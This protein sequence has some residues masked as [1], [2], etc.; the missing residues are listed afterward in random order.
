MTKQAQPY[1]VNIIM[2]LVFICTGALNTSIYAQQDSLDNPIILQD[3]TQQ[4]ANNKKAK[5]QKNNKFRP[6]PR[7]A[8]LLA[9]LPGGGQIY[10][11]SY[12]KIPI[13]YGGFVGLGY[14]VL[15]SRQKYQ[16]YRKAYLAAVD[17]TYSVLPICGID[18]SITEVSQLKSLRDNNQ[19]M[20]EWSVI[21]FTAFYGLTILEAFVNAHL[22]SFDV[23]DDLTMTVR[24]GLRYNSL[25]RNFEPSV[26]LK[27][28]PKYQAKIKP[29]DLF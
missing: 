21:A 18:T 9:L 23:S 1:W 8:T 19:Q 7:T 6:V 3:T 2:L 17:T 5:R 12:W 28:V 20:F 27:I 29:P 10:N 24:T 22:K 11:R 14:W 4:K 16:C 25:M 15:D 13:V 26:G